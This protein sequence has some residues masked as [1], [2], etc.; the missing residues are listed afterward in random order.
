MAFEGVVTTVAPVLKSIKLPFRTKQVDA[1]LFPNISEP[2]G[3]FA[4]PP[5]PEVDHAWMRISRNMIFGITERDVL[6]LHKD[7]EDAVKFNPEWE[8]VGGEDLYLGVLDV[9]HQVHCLN[10]LRQNLITNYDYYWGDI[11]GFKPPVFRE[12]HL[13]HC[14][15]ILLQAIMC[16]SDIGVVT[17]IWS[18]DRSVPTPDFGINRKCRDFEA[19]LKWR[20]E[21]DL[22]GSFTKFKD[23]RAPQGAPVMPGDPHLADLYAN[24]DEYKDGEYLKQLHIKGCNE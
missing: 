14:T 2:M 1:R 22:D 11:Y 20:D 21:T 3:V 7:P 24:A 12:T 18:E 13:W 10:M 5:S 23:Y 9:F 19:L 4:A 8:V 17:H 16:H 6:R 15:S